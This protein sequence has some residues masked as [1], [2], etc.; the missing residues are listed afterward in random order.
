MEICCVTQVLCSNL[1]VW[2]WV[3]GGR[4]VQEEPVA[5]SC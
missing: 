3:G 5:D 1:E 2:N 4:E